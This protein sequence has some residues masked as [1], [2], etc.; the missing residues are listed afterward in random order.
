MM[1]NRTLAAAIVL[2]GTATAPTGT[3]AQTFDRSRPP[4]LAPPPELRLPPI[5][6]RTLPNGLRLL[7]VEHHELPLAT[8]NLVVRSG[9][10]Q[11]PVGRPGTADF[12]ASMLREG[13]G[14]R[15]TLDI[16][17]QM[18]FLGAVL[19]TNA[20]WDASTVFLHTPTA[21]L[22]SALAL[23]ADIALRPT[24][25][26]EEMERMRGRRLTSILQRR[27]QPPVIADLTYA[28]LLFGSEHPYGQPLGGTEA[29]TR[30]VQREELERYYR[31][32]FRPNN[33]TMIIV[34]AVTPDDIQARIARLF[35]SWESAPVPSVTL[36][37]PSGVERTT[38]YLIDKPGA[39]QASFRLGHVGVP[40]ST[41]DYFALVVMNTVLGGSFTSRLMQNL[42]ENR[43]YTYGAYSGFAFRRFAGP[44]VSEAEVVAMKSDSALIE[45]MKELRAIKVPVPEDEL[46][47]AK[48]YL[49]LRFPGGFETTTGIANQLVPLVVYDL[50]MD[51]HE[52]Y[53]RQIE[54]VM[55]ADLQR[56]AQRYINPERMTI[57]VVGDRAQ[58]EQPLRALGMA[59]IVVRDVTGQPLP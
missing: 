43:G 54:A 32:H 37:E 50:E 25:P 1:R 13:A 23:F 10:S 9:A 16:A 51:Y 6:E 11:N 20:G 35:G 34:G 57:V 17:D 19:S 49:Q 40:R 58:I 31:T 47:K 42:R 33:A 44:F 56:V 27:D 30:D 39:T 2:C 14:T 15:S 45:F 7:I 12:T 5:V 29:S 48:R 21:Q 28:S 41:N 55:Q 38:I 4:E 52:G 24:F 59:E 3:A 22:D 8:F 26:A 53:V 36:N 18:A 46:L